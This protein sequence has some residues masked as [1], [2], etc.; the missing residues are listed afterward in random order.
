MIIT[1]VNRSFH[2]MTFG[3]LLVGEVVKTINNPMMAK[4]MDAQTNTF[5]AIFC[6]VLSYQLE[7]FMQIAPRS[8]RC[9]NLFCVEMRD[10]LRV[11]EK[12]KI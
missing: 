3:P 9:S 1:D 2:K 10:W 4:A 6:I 12:M 8:P 5:V 11:V 7:N